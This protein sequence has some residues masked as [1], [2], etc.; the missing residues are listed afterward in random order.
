MKAAA[1]ANDENR[2]EYVRVLPEP[3][4]PVR[5]DINGPDFIEV[6]NAVDI[7]EGG[8]RLSVKHRFEGCHVDQ[9]ASFIVHLP[10]PINK[11]FRFEGQITHVRDDSFG[12]RFTNLTSEARALVRRYVELM[13]G[14]HSASDYLRDMFG[15]SR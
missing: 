5:V 13:G 7:S 6:I 10:Q 3:H 8:I 15:M 11:L 9:P 12:V 1:I 14:K 4:A 2:R